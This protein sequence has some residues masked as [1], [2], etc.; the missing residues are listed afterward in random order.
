MFIEFQQAVSS[1]S[2]LTV[3][4][5]LVDDDEASAV[6]E[7]ALQVGARPI[8]K[9][10]DVAAQGILIQRESDQA[11]EA[12]E[13]LPHV[14]WAVVGEDAANALEKVHAFTPSRHETAR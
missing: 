3:L 13:S 11:F 7:E 12:Q 14:D 8:G 1:E 10:K 4:K 5:P 6:P 2:K 9:D